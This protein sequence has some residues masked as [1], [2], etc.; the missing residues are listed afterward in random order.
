MEAAN[1]DTVM[2]MGSTSTARLIQKEYN[3]VKI[4]H[5]AG[6]ATELTMHKTWELLQYLALKHKKI[7]GRG[8]GC[9]R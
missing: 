3:A 1:H 2:A 5:M 4:A 8:Q 6:A 9:I 7:W